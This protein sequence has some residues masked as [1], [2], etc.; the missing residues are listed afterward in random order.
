[1]SESPKRGWDFDD[2]LSDEELAIWFFAP[3]Q[4]EVDDESTQAVTGICLTAADD[5][6][7]VHLMFVG[8]DDEPFDSRRTNCSRI[9]TRSRRT[10]SAIRGRTL[11]IR[12]AARSV[13]LTIR[14]ESSDKELVVAQPLSGPSTTP[15]AACA[16]CS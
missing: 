5:A 7:I 6:E 12:M 1:M 11:T 13:P 16:R 14:P 8:T 4:A 10:G 2:E 15:C 3:S 9:S